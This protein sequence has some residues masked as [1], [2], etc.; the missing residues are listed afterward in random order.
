MVGVKLTALAACGRMRTFSEVAFQVVIAEASSPA[1]ALAGAFVV[2]RTDAASSGE[3][4][5][6]VKRAEVRSDFD[7]DAD[8]RIITDSRD[9]A[10]QLQL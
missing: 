4:V 10:Q 8:G 6:V 5:G 9:G 2:A 3:T 7:Q 1:S